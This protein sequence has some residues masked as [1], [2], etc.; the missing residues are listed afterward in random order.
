VDQQAEPTE[1]GLSLEARD[2]VVRQSDALAGRPEHELPRMQDE[3]LRT[4]DLDELRELGHWLSNV[5]VRVS[6][7]RE[8]PELRVDVEIDRRWLHARLVERLD[9]DSACRDLLADVDVGQ[10]HRRAMLPAR[11]SGDGDPALER[12]G[13]GA[14]IDRLGR[15]RQPFLD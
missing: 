7:V 1:T 12:R 10:D 15:D 11:C 8:Y 6:R 9:L 2:H 13:S 5:D 3:R 14:G 4:L